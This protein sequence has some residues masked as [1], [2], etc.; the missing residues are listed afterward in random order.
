MGA[1]HI[2]T[3]ELEKHSETWLL[4]YILLQTR[5]YDTS[6]DTKCSNWPKSLIFAMV[7]SWW[8]H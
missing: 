5:L 7:L 1:V 8:M 2:V 3:A 4:H 6:Y